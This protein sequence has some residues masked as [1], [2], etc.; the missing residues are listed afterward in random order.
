MA[1]SRQIVWLG[2]VG[3]SRLDRAGA[4]GSADAGRHAFCGIHTNGEGRPELG[5]VFQRL[6]IQ[7]QGIALLGVQRQTD[8]TATE[9]RHKIDNLRR[10]LLGRTDQ[11]ALVLAIFG[12]HK[13]DHL[14][15]PQVLK[16][17]R[18]IAE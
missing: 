8:Q 3:D 10:R 15:L 13:N 9:F 12:V 14:A 7:A 2:A 11:I 5:G 1:R 18:Y 16:H 4:I 17:F 6:G